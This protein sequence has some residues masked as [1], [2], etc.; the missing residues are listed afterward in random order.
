MAEYKPKVYKPNFPFSTAA[1]LLI[2]T[3]TQTK[4][5]GVKTYPAQGIRINVSF[6]TYG[7]TEVAQDGVYAVVDTANIETWYRSDITSACRIKI[8]ATGRFYEVIGTPENIDMRNQFL[9]FKVR[10]VEGNP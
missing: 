10:G 4:G 5:V 8:L 7:G 1:E 9:R 2:P 6:K 3:V